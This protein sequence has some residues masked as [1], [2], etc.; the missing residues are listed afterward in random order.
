MNF[1][2]T[3]LFVSTSVLAVLMFG[4]STQSIQAAVYTFE[5]TLAPDAE[6]VVMTKVGDGFGDTAAGDFGPPLSAGIQGDGSARFVDSGS[7]GLDGYEINNL[8]AGIATYTVDMSVRA[9][10]TTLP[11]SGNDIRSMG[12]SDGTNQ[13]GIRIQPTGMTLVNGSGPVA[14][15]SATVSL[16]TLHKIRIT[17]TPSGVIIYDLENDLD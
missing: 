16:V 10:N 15:G 9:N 13:R 11:P 14:G 6:S 12:I 5:M 2:K 1:R 4:F 3:A 17:V 8:G 7:N